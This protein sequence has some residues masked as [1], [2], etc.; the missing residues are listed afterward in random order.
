MPMVWSS[1]SKPFVSQ[2]IALYSL[3]PS[4]KSVLA[5]KDL[6]LWFERPCLIKTNF[7]EFKSFLITG[8]VDKLMLY[9]ALILSFCLESAFTFD[10]VIF[11][12]GLFFLENVSCFFNDFVIL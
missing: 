8:G 2:S 3:V 7:A 5:I 1:G 6:M 10:F 4:P 11:Y 12:D 9:F